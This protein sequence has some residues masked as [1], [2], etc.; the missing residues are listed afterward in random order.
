MSST[1]PSYTP[2]HDQWLSR[3]STTLY[4]ADLSKLKA[5]PWLGPTAKA[6]VPPT[7]VLE[8]HAATDGTQCVGLAKADS[9]MTLEPLAEQAE[10]NSG[11]EKKGVSTGSTFY[12]VSPSLTL[13]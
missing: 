13:T 10:R 8:L 1:P 4:L 2:Q 6:A 3:P 9:A 5:P 12:T 11:R 7:Q